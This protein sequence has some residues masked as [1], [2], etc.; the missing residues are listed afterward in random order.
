[1]ANAMP[2]RFSTKYQDDETDMVY[3]PPGRY[4]IPSTGRWAGR[5]P[6]A[7]PGFQS[8]LRR[9]S[10][11][12]RR[13]Q[14]NWLGDRNLC[15]FVN[16]DPVGKIDPDGLDTWCPYPYPGHACSDPKPC[17][18]GVAC[19]DARKIA[20]G[21]KTLTDRW[22]D[23][24]RYLDAN[25]VQLDPDDESGVSCVHS[26]NSILAFMAPVPTCWKC[27]IQRRGTWGAPFGGGDQNSIKCDVQRP[28]GWQFSMVFDW[29][30]EKYEGYKTYSPIPFSRYQWIFPYRPQPRVQ[31]LVD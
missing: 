24:A 13:L 15:A 16:N 17:D 5:D 18:P 29:W 22:R 2:F 20:D 12:M 26:A 6:I 10:A 1:M 28:Y 11:I 27:Y 19:C 21:L 14:G 3:Y 23:A 30:Y 25:G 8:I 7:E 9:K 31:R 4:Y